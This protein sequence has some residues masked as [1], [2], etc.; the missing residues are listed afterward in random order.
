[1]YKYVEIYGGKVRDLKTSHLKYVEFCSIF[2]PSCYW[3]DVTNVDNVAI[4]DIVKFS[5]D[6]GTY[7]EKPKPIG[8]TL[9]SVRN[10]KLEMLDFMFKQQ[11]EDASILSS[12]GVNMN[13][14]TRAKNDVDGLLQQMETEGL[15]EIEFM[16]YDDI[17]VPVTYEELKTLQL[18]IIK[19]GHSIYNQKWAYRDA[20]KAATSIEELNGIT[21]QFFMYDFINDRLMD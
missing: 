2:D 11:L 8:V 20:I 3:V 18:E 16:S 14:G 1:M 10:A 15:T 5:A 9:E 12:L 19:N 21:I 13:A 4:G 7:F 17:K 6:V